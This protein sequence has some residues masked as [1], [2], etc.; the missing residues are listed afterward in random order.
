M[1]WAS[2]SKQGLSAFPKR[3]RLDVSLHFC[4]S[5]KAGCL[6]HR[7][8]GSNDRK[9]MGPFSSMLHCPTVLPLLTCQGSV[10]FLNSLF[11]HSTNVSWA[12]TGRQ[13]LFEMLKMQWTKLI[14]DPIS[15]QL[16]LLS[17][18]HHPRWRWENLKMLILLFRLANAPVQGSP[19]GLVNSPIFIDWPR[20][21]FWVNEG[22][23][24]SGLPEEVWNLYQKSP[25]GLSQ[26]SW[27]GW[28][29]QRTD[30]LDNSIL[31]HALVP[32]V[33]KV[34]TAGSL[35]QSK[36][37]QHSCSGTVSFFTFTGQLKWL[38]CN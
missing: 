15:L 13:A 6:L 4:L 21:P 24:L 1:K 38:P 8:L 5:S 10:S 33:L 34:S 12:S 14:K 11:F 35:I 22:Y 32:G 16:S 30:L 25:E 36:P 28:T 26:L 2:S 3:P 7:P 31:P 29:T 37:R 17:F 9:S 20:S 19:I 23:A 27:W 18:V